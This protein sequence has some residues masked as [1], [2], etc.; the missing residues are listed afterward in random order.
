MSVAASVGAARRPVMERVR[1]WAQ[2]ALPLLLFFLLPL[3]L[4]WPVL[5]GQ[6]TLVPFD[7]LYQG[8]PWHP[9]REAVG[10]GDPHNELVS[11]L[12]L[13]NFQWKQFAVEQYRQGQLPLWQPNQLAGSP[14]LAAG[15]HSM[16]Y[17]LSLLFLLLPLPVAF[18]WFTALSLALAGMTMYVFG[19]VLGLRAPAALLAGLIYQGSGFLTISVV[20]PMIVAGAAWL[21]LLLAALHRLGQLARQGARSDAFLPWLGIGSIA[22]GLTALAGHVEILYYTLLVGGLYGVSRQISVVRSQTT[23]WSRGR[24]ALPLMGWGGAMVAVGLMLGAAQIVPLYELVSQNFRATGATLDEVRGYAWPLRQVASFVVP[25][26][27]G[28]PSRHDFYNL[29][30]RAWQPIVTQQPINAAGDTISLDHVAWFKGTPSWKNYVEGAG[31][32]GILPLLLALVALAEAGRRTSERGTVGFFAGLSAWSLL[33]IFGSPLYAL[34]FYGLPGWRQLHSPFR[35]VFPLTL[36]VSVLAGIGWQVVAERGRGRWLGWLAGGTGAVGLLLLGAMALAPGLWVAQAAK[37][38]DRSQLAQWAFGGSATLF[39]SYQWANFLHL[40]LALL[41][42]G[43]VLGAARQAVLG[44][45]PLL[46]ALLITGADLGAAA[47]GFMPATPTAVAEFT[48]PAVAWLQ[49]RHEPGAW[50]YTALEKDWKVLN[51]NSTMRYGLEDVRGYDSIIVKHY[52]RF[53]EALSPQPQLDFNRVAPL[54]AETPPDPELLDLLNVRYLVTDQALAWPGWSLAHEGEV[55]IYEN[56]DVLPRAFLLGNGTYWGLRSQEIPAETLQALDPRTEVL[57]QGDEGGLLARD[58]LRSNVPLTPVTIRVYTPN[59]V[60]MEIA[61]AGGAWLVFTDVDF[62]GWRAFTWKAGAETERELP[63]MRANGAFRAVWVEGGEQTIR[64]KYSPTSVKTGFF[65]SFL[66]VAALGLAAA[67]WAWGRI[68]QEREDEGTVRRVAKNSFAPMALQLFNKA[69]DTV[70]AAFTARLLGV[71]ALGQYAFAVTLIWGIIIFTNFGLGTLLTRDAARDPEATN[72]LFATTLVLRVALYL[73]A[74]PALGVL[75]VLWPLLEQWRGVSPPTLEPA[76]TWAI[77]L[78]ALGLLPSNLADAVTAVFRAREKFEVPALVATIATFFKVSIGAGVLL[79]GWGIVGLAATSIL[80]N[81]ATLCI[82]SVLMV[83]TLYRPALR[84]ERLP[85]RGMLRDALP[86]MINEFLATAFF[87]I[88][89]FLLKPMRGNFDAGY[90][91]V[92]Y[93]FIDGLLILPSTFTLAIFPVMSRYAQ[94][95]PDALLRA[96]VLSLRWLVLIALPLALLTTRYAEGIV[97]AFGGPEFLP[98]SARALQIL[99]WF[100]PFSFVN[101][102]LQ[103]VLIAADRQHSLT[104]AYLW[105]LG[106]NIVANLLAI[107]FVGLYGAALVTVLS[108]IALLLPFDRLMRRSV[109][110]LPWLTLFARPL[111]ALGAAAL[112]L[113]WGGLPFWLAIPASL[114]LYLLVLVLL[115]TFGPA[116]RALLTRLR[117]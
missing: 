105:A 37:L 77:L 95:A 64:W 109:G 54:R 20:F 81:F 71:E 62:A 21:P 86:L 117:G 12:V 34:L 69:V 74:L 42:A 4:F 114:T 36:A 6:A 104:R 100:L 13:E 25:D 3:F 76:T 99:I 2:P 91:N 18:G 52:V 7:A 17:P 55:R 113:W 93:K 39:V 66:G 89:Q 107:R 22:I 96:T 57:L 90:Y 31:Y 30:A 72:R 8:Q 87:R 75:L 23:A 98:A 92:A 50:R 67:Y 106:F 15:Q 61:P 14:F 78:L 26:L 51:A 82:L 84:P 46:L 115:R 103:Y 80:T 116:D 60:T 70:F 29:E 10:V 97:L 9:F 43:L 1:G 53:M 28:D 5:W 40:G 38:L 41:G 88:D 102:L 56:E 24:A 63:V 58:A 85:W 44:R 47:W 32:L 16:L 68:Y 11:D 19:R 65:G 108:E 48:P 112:P 35:W 45:W 49:E 94:G 110:P 79:V 83:R 27:L 59:E 33:M 101:S 73:A 111:V